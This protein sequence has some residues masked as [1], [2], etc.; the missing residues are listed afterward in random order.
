MFEN[1]DVVEI[2]RVGPPGLVFLLSLAAYSLLH[3]EQ[4]KAKPSEKIIGCIKQ[5]MYINI[6]LAG[7]T[8]ISP[9][10]EMFNPT[11]Q[12][13]PF[14]AAINISAQIQDNNTAAVCADSKY[15]GRYLLIANESGLVQVRGDL[16]NPCEGVDNIYL[17]TQVAEN[18]G[19]NDTN[20]PIRLKAQA[21]GPGQMFVLP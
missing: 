18:L 16:S 15:S 17:N 13:M 19:L 12:S 8:L 9:I 1:M 5:F 21:A 4:K 3:Q 6:L 7:L 10:L 2:L 11:E 14:E 20:T